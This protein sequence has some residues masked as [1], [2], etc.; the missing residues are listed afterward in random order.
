MKTSF[1]HRGNHALIGVFGRGVGREGGTGWLLEIWQETS[2]IAPQL[3]E[4]LS[5]HPP[6]LLLGKSHDLRIQCSLT[7]VMSSFWMTTW[8]RGVKSIS[9]LQLRQIAG[10]KT[11]KKKKKNW[12]RCSYSENASNAFGPHYA[13]EIEKRNNHQSSFSKRSVLNVLSTRKRKAGVFKFL[14]FEEPFRKVPFSCGI[15]VDGRPNRR[16]KAAFSNSSDVMPV[17][18]KSTRLNSSHRCL[19][20]VPR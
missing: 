20:P 11:L 18:R 19:F 13:E 7:K 6:W 2:Q 14:R 10:Y 8:G 3:D 4:Q 1:L 15:S 12:K 9:P 17:D 16:N 5:A